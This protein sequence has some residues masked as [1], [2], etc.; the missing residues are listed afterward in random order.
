MLAVIALKPTKQMFPERDHTHR[1]THA[2]THVN[3]QNSHTTSTSSTVISSTEIVPVLYNNG[4][5]K[6]RL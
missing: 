5:T 3:T 1:D 6:S 2:R 4:E